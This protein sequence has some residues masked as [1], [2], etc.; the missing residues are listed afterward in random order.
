MKRFVKLSKNIFLALLFVTTSAVAQEKV[1]DAELGNFANAVVSIQSI[2]QEAQTTMMEVVDNSG[3]E[4]ERFNQI[5]QAK[6]QEDTETLETLTEDESK[7]FESVMERFEAMQAVFQKQMEDAVVKQNI[8][9]ERFD[10][11]AQMMEND[12]EL[13][14]RLQEKMK[15]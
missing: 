5:Y 8:T 1:T 15:Q 10:A 11:I 6:M 2:N 9:L 12:F 4:L 7:N 13:Q 14:T 3:F